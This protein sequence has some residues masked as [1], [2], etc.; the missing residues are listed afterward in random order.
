MGLRFVALL[1]TQEI[2]VIAVAL[3]VHGGCDVVR[4]AFLVNIV[5]RSSGLFRPMYHVSH[6]C[7]LSHQLTHRRS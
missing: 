4:N 2:D 7:R 5:C 3:S 1:E 6:L